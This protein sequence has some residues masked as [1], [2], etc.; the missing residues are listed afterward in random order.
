MDIRA[1]SKLPGINLALGTLR[2]NPLLSQAGID[3]VHANLA[4]GPVVMA[5]EGEI[6]APAS[7]SDC[8]PR[9]VLALG[10]RH[11]SPDDGQCW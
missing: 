2:G 9:V 4:G 10:E 6:R 1:L 8:H 3:A 7:D 11:E 5:N